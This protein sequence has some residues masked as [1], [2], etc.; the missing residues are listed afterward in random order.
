MKGK[1][2]Y[3]SILECIDLKFK[4]TNETGPRVMDAVIEK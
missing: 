3:H 4:L 1:K 2:K